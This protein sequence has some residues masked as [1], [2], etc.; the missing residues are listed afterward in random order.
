[1]ARGSTSGFVPKVARL[2]PPAR[3]GVRGWP[4]FLAVASVIALMAVVLLAMG[5]EPWCTCGHVKLWHGVV[6]SSEN[7]QHLTDWYTFSHVLVV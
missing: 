2:W 7:S 3:V 6:A 5:R 1:M 4:Y